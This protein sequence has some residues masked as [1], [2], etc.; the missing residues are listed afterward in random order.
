VEWLIAAND[1]GSNEWLKKCNNQLTSIA[2]SHEFIDSLLRRPEM[3]TRLFRSMSR[4]HLTKSLNEI[5]NRLWTRQSLDEFMDMTYSN[6]ASAAELI[7]I[8]S[9]IA[10]NEW[11]FW[12][13]HRLQ[14]NPH[15]IHNLTEVLSHRRDILVAWITTARKSNNPD[16]INII[17]NVVFDTAIRRS[18]DFFRPEQLASLEWYCRVTNNNDLEKLVKS[19]I[20]NN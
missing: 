16:W 11:S 7:R 15:V 6:P 10:G 9:E 12:F 1:L 2:V 3:A 19:R 20:G 5:L 8:S 4:R 13:I 18:I 17:G 14:D